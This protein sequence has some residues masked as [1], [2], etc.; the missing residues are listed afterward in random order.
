MKEFKTRV[1]FGVLCIVCSYW[2]YNSL[3]SE[4]EMNAQLEKFS[5]SYEVGT[6]GYCIDS[7]LYQ[8]PSW[9]YDQAEDYLFGGDYK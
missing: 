1:L 4:Q 8:H 6:D 5:S 2:A 3:I 9:S 7:I